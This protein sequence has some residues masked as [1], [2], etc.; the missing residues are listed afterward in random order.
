MKE[1]QADNYD[2]FIVISC[3]DKCN[4]CLFKCEVVVAD[5]KQVNISC[6]HPK[7][8]GNPIHCIYFKNRSKN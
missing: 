6:R 7:G 2:D 3:S 8:P 1:F 5:M 4:D